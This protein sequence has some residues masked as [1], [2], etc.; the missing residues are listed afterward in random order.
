MSIR[1]ACFC[2]GLFIAGSVFS[3]Y[4]AAADQAP[5]PDT[6][7][8]RME[9][10]VADD[11][12][13]GSSQIR[14]A[15]WLK[16][17]D[18][19]L[20]LHPLVFESN[21]AADKHMHTG[22]L[23]DIRGR[24]A[25][26]GI[27]VESLSLVSAS[28]AELRLADEPAEEPVP[29]TLEL[30]RAV[31]FI[32]NF[33]DAQNGY[34]TA[35]IAGFM[36]TNEKNVDGLYQASSFQQL[37]F[38]PDVDGNGQMDVFGP[39]DID[40]INATD[41]CNYYDW[42]VAADQAAQNAG[43]DLTL[44]QHRVYALPDQAAC[45]WSG[46]ANL[47][48]GTYCRAWIRSGGGA[49]YAHELGHNLDWNHSSTDPGNDGNIDEEYGDRSG[50]MGWPA[51]AQAN[52]PHRDQLSWFDTYPGTLVLTHTGGTFQLDA[53]ELDPGVD[54]VGVQVV[55]LPKA[56]TN[57][58]YYISY[59]RQI[60]TYPSVGD[61][62]N[63]VNIHRYQ[64][65]GKVRTAHITNLGKDDTFTDAENGITVTA[66]AVGGQTATVDV[67]MNGN[68]APTADFTFD[69]VGLDVQFTDNS[70]DADGTIE[71]YQWDFDDGQSSTVASPSHSFAA[72]G[73]Y[74]VSLLV[75][76]DDGAGDS[77][78]KAVTVGPPNASPVADFT[79]TVN[80]LQ[81]RFTD[82]S[83]DSDGT[84]A[85]R[86]WHFGDNTT[87]TSA[88]PTH[89]FSAAGTYTVTLTVTDDDGA[90]DSVAKD[91]TVTAP[92]APPTADFSFSAS[93]LQVQ[94]TDVSSDSDGS[95][96]SRQWNFG[97]G[98]TSSQVNPG[99]IYAA[100]GTY[101]VRLTVTDNDDADATVSK[102]VSVVTAN[103]SPHADFAYSADGLAVHFT[104]ASSDSDGTIADHQWDFGDG[105]NSAQSNPSHTYAAAG[106]Y[107]VRLTVTDNNGATDT[108]TR[109]ITINA[110]A[111]N[112]P[113]VDFEFTTDGLT[114][115]L[116]ASC[117]DPDGAIQSY[118]WDFGDGNT[119]SE[120]NPAHIYAS[121]G[122]FT[123]RLTVTDDDG[124]A[125]SAEKT[126]SVQ[127]DPQPD[128]EKTGG[129]G[130]GCFIRL[131]HPY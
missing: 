52:A 122:D 39:F 77:I 4:L 7:I 45:A 111:N 71:A 42:A 102:S 20:R 123:V 126:V 127:A 66:T 118:H 34:D 59:R 120:Q 68:A 32:L 86:R 92:N 14:Y 79:Y 69:A 99:H 29:L 98:S 61:Y 83:S 93:N 9:V 13:S 19:T 88:N 114:I 100:A 65:Y 2:F 128:D 131:L 3:S 22:D 84:I 121:D 23:V 44:Y 40:D 43:I 24:G 113:E 11:F 58:Y 124:A 97:D 51:W 26:D 115:A 72:A 28:D 105:A 16:Q 106:T 53:L 8:G 95:I 85:V 96:A 46:L 119:S 5:A 89:T 6:F 62:A 60:G 30:R 130:G 91:V 103:G 56:D 82:A 87:S 67:V 94:F 31:V 108:A 90:G 80:G 129:G 12:R 76:D 112:A 81:V 101:T 57:E 55:K 47:G 64:G 1:T 27:H 70:S 117:S 17:A 78:T 41:T 33:D 15:V 110:L 75:T 125:A 50:I 54:A 74:V 116:T 73:T 37:G 109:S 18:G 104:D 36:Y 49:V 107:S 25:S 63:V 35:D 48:C 38:D 10:T 21:P